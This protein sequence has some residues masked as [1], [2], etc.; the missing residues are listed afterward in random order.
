MSSEEE[1][2]NEIQQE[3]AA[4]IAAYDGSVPFSEFAAHYLQAH[5]STHDLST[6]IQCIVPPSD[7]RYRPRMSEPL[8]AVSNVIE[9]KPG[10]RYLLVFKGAITREQVAYALALL[11]AMHIPS[12]GFALWDGVGLDVVEAPM[13]EH[14]SLDVVAPESEAPHD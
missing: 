8:K 9:L 10:H 11:E 13:K 6:V 7:P 3:L 12:I 1:H 14:D 5:P 4:L 2:N